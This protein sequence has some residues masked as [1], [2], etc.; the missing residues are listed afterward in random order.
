M[1]DPIKPLPADALAAQIAEMETAMPTWPDLQRLMADIE[2]KG[3]DA[4]RIRDRA[5]PSAQNPYGL[6]QRC[7]AATTH[8]HED[9][10]RLS[11]RPPAGS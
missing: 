2:A 4:D 9:H 10:R 5:E 8:A 1:S 11:T 6:H 3:W 7:R